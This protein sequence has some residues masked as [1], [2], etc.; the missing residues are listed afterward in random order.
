MTGVFDELGYAQFNKFSA[1][2][3]NAPEQSSK[4]QRAVIN[5]ATNLDFSGDWTA[6]KG[7]EADTAQ[8]DAGT[9]C[10]GLPGAKIV[11]TTA[12]ETLYRQTVTVSAPG[13]YTLSAYVK[14]EGLTG[15]GAFVRLKVGSG[16]WTSL[17]VKGST[18]DTA[19]G[20]GTEGWE[21]VQATG[22]VDAAGAVQLELVN[23]SPGGTAWFACPQLESGTIANRVNLLVNGDFARTQTETNGT[24]TFPADWEAQNGLTSSALNG[25]VPAAEADLPACL[26]GNATR[27]EALPSHANQSF[28]Q[29][30]SASGSAGDVYV[31]GGWANTRSVAAGGEHFEPSLVVRFLSGGEFK[32]LD[33][34]KFNTEHAGWQF[35]CWAISAPVDYDQIL[36]AFAYERNAQTGMFT[37]LFLHREQFGASFAYDDDKNLIS[38][39]NL[40]GEKSKMEYDG[41]DNLTSYVR[42][43]AAEEDKYLFTY[44]DTDGEKKKHLV[45]TESTPMGAKNHYTYDAYG[46]R[47]T[48]KTQKDGEPALIQS[49]TAWNSEG[50]YAV[51]STDARG[52]S[53]TKT[54]DPDSGLVYNVTDPAGQS[55][56][57][58]YDSAN[59]VTGVQ[60]EVAATDSEPAKVYR[61]AYTYE[62]DRIKTVSHNTTGSDCDVTYTFDYDDLG[63]KTTVKVGSQTLSANVYADDRGGLLKEVQYGNGG[64]VS[65]EYDGFDRM[66]GVK[67]D[68]EASPRYEYE[69]GANGR[70]AIVRDHHLNRTAQTEYDLSERPCR[71]TI[72]DAETGELIYRTSLE[73]DEQ[74]RLKAFR[75]ETA[76]GAHETTFSYDK[77]NRTTQIRYGSDGQKVEYAYDGLGRVTSR[78]VTNGTSAYETAYEYETGDAEK[79]GAGATTPLVKKITQ[80]GMNF[81]YAYDSRGNITSEKR[82][83]VETKY[84]YDAL[85]QLVYV[86]DPHEGAIWYYKYD[87]GGNILEKRRYAR[88]ADGTQGAL[89]ETVPYEYGDA[90]WKDKLTK[91]NG[92]TITY[93]AIGNPLDDG[94]RRYE[95][96][97]GRRL[98]K[99]WVRQKPEDGIHDGVDGESNTTLRIQFTNGNLLTGETAATTVSA[100]VL[101]GEADITS[102]YAASAFVWTRDT[103]DAA[104]DATWNAAHNGVKQF[105]MNAA[106]LTEN[107][108]LTCTLTG[109][110][111]DYGTVYVDEHMNLIHA[112]AEADANDTLHLENGILSVETEGNEYRLNGNVLGVIRHRL[113][114]SVTA[115]AWVYTAA[116]EKLVEFKYDTNG[117]RTQKKVTDHGQVV[118][119]EYIYHGKKLVGLT[120]GDDTLHFFYDAQGRPAKVLFNNGAYVYAY[121]VQDDVIGLLDA[122][123]AFVVKYQ[124]DVWGGVLT[125]E[126][127]MAD[128]FGEMNPIRYRSYIYDDETMTYDL[129]S[130]RYSPQF[131]RFVNADKK[132]QTTHFNGCNMYAYVLSN[133]VNMIDLNGTDAVWI[134]E[135]ESAKQ[136]GHSGLMVQ[137]SQG[138]WYYFFW[139]PA[140][141]EVSPE[142]ITGIDRRCIV[143]KIDLQGKE[144]LDKDSI[145]EILSA[146]SNADVARRANLIT[147]TYYFEGDYTKTYE[148]I[149][150]YES[151]DEK[152]NLLTNNCVQKTLSAFCQSDS[153]FVDVSYG[154]LDGT[155]PNFA[156]AKVALIPRKKSQFA[157]R[158]LLYNIFFSN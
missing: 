102:E 33:Y 149:R 3:A 132:T 78:K 76:D 83:G 13:R 142:L 43:G 131:N 25:I 20:A 134:Q 48:A 111:P 12:A 110:S 24:R 86:N 63:R 21:R 81:E 68:G 91:Y 22:Q 101:K 115:E 143:E 95:W 66:T 100:K 107:V 37:N 64:K 51:S 135:R 44:G 122:T 156:A 93:D 67:H 152:Y 80:A 71:N 18:A 153:R 106:D 55:V 155:V 8:Q 6:Q 113:N 7:A 99:V 11:K 119:T 23:A 158:L 14:A 147:D 17:P 61:N 59:R 47:L 9:R 92:R 36:I 34:H 46:N 150:G 126:G 108:K 40:A 96:E 73:Y 114:G 77:D 145:I 140:S 53:V 120:C 116:P 79:Y 148:A 128:V 121:N 58:S 26:S 141:E 38:T 144:I 124:Y 104:A 89:K 5:L 109:T 27:I 137:D 1:T 57:Y 154:L 129:R 45:R 62:N 29:Y 74:N 105:T 31:F 97:A 28:V 16:A 32:S 70:A 117:L 90:N 118:T 60:A 146:S 54:V 123:G 15:G 41:F 2:L 35:G 72:R 30:I 42:P 88:S 85:G 136:H 130:R 157:W 151:S 127:I 69:Y 125:I 39:S 138:D 4:L 10:L 56:A 50:N 94:E 139:G 84:A 87:Q 19:W 65:Y 82:N 49:E 112:P 103:G 75:E 98:K 133:P 52:H